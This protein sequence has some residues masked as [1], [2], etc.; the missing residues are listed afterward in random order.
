M[1]TFLEMQTA[2]KSDLNVGSGNNF[3]TDTVIKS[4]LN[5][6][7]FKVGGLFRWPET[8]DAKKTSTVATQE[9][10]DYPTTWRPDSVWKLMV[11]DEDF[12]E[13]LSFKD[14]QYEV[15]NDIPSGKERLWTSQWRRYFFYPT[16]TTNGTNNIVIWGQEAVETLV[17][18]GAIT[19]FSYS[20]P[21]CNEAVVMEAVAILKNK[22][23][24]QQSGALISQEAKQILVIA[25]GK[26]KQEQSKYTKTLP[27]FDVPNYFQKNALISDLIGNF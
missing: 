15:E 26:I 25:W 16:P 19:I 1:D 20:M 23:Q 11:D 12:G 6:A 3:Y 14:F 5:R 10:Y 24:E 13:P 21:E 18:D 2:L 9:Y 8:E 4:V 27:F 22:G 7:Y 17:A